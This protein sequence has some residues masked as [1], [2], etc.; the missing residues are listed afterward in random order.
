MTTSHK[1]LRAK[2]RAEMT[3]DYWQSNADM[4]DRLKPSVSSNMFQELAKEERRRTV[5]VI[6]DG[7]DPRYQSAFRPRAGTDKEQAL[8]WICNEL[9]RCKWQTS[10]VLTQRC[11][12]AGYGNAEWTDNHWR[13]IITEARKTTG[14]T[15]TAA[16]ARWLGTWRGGS[17]ESEH[18]RSKAS[19]A[20]LQHAMQTYDCNAPNIDIATPPPTP[21]VND[22][23]NAKRFAVDVIRQAIDEADRLRYAS[24]KFGQDVSTKM[25]H[26]K[27]AAAWLQTPSATEVYCGLADIDADD[28]AEWSEQRH[29]RP[30]FSEAE[31]RYYYQQ[32]DAYEHRRD[33]ERRTA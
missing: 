1:D 30:R 3:R 22:P 13:A 10:R 32:R 27:Y 14:Q 19:K 7:P 11:L 31:L 24:S 23:D 6:D 15:L 28:L 4:Y 5:P 18:K 9:L 16:Q 29:G 17:I 25:V 12:K 21:G 26:W 8:A 2:I 33:E 20:R